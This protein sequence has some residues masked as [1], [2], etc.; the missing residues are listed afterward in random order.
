M[1]FRLSYPFAEIIS[2]FLFIK[3]TSKKKCQATKEFLTSVSSLS[4]IF[5]LPSPFFQP[6]GHQL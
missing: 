1:V 6:P 4:G 2:S 5:S 3:Q